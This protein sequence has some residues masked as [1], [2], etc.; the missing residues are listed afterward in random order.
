MLNSYAAGKSTLAPYAEYRKNYY[1]FRK[2][3]YKSA[4]NVINNTSL[5]SNDL[6]LERTK[7]FDVGLINYS[8]LNK[9]DEG[10]KYFNEL[11]SKYPSDR[12]S[13]M[14]IVLYGAQK[15]TKDNDKNIA[16]SVTANNAVLTNYPNPFNPSTVISYNIP[17]NSSVKLTVYDVLGKE[18]KVLVNE[19][20]NKGSYQVTF[21][22]TGLSSGLYFYQLQAGNINQIRKMV[23]TK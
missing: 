22:G 5:P 14:A 8:C 20:Q 2:G 3:D 16:N 11:V 23:L 6:E 7:L 19:T 1:Y 17:E 10:L 4:L 9:K 12:L 18:V 13:E 21:N 15:G